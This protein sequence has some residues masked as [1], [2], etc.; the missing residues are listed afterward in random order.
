MGSE[1]NGLPLERTSPLLSPLNKYEYHGRELEH[2][3]LV[4]PLL[5]YL[6]WSYYGVEETW[7]GLDLEG[8]MHSEQWLRLT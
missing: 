8:S 5:Q 3:A 6:V 7:L 1:G 4:L 2:D